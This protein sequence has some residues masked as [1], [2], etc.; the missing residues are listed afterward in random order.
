MLLA[1]ARRRAPGEDDHGLPAP[2]HDQPLSGFYEWI[3]R[4]RGHRRIAPLNLW[5]VA[6]IMA[7]AVILIESAITRQ[8]LFHRRI[9]RFMT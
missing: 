1:E 3:F 2:D 5:S 9:D 7:K 8:S 6:G 4:C